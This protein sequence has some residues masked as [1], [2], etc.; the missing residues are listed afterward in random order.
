MLISPPYTL[1]KDDVRRCVPPIGLAYI[2]A[3]L[4]CNGYDVKILDAA[5]EGYTNLR[6]KDIFVTYGLTDEELKKKIIDFAP[7]IIGVSCIFSIQYHNVSHVLRIAKSIDSNI[8][9]IVGG[10]HP[11]YSLREALHNDDID[12]VV[13][14]EGEF[15]MLNLLNA[16]N[17]TD[18][19]KDESAISKISGVSFRKDGKY[20]INNNIEY[21]KDLDKLPFPARHLLNMEKYFEINLPQSPFPKG[22]RIA[23]L[24]TS[25]G[26]VVKCVFCTTTNFWGNRYRVRNAKNVI[27]E[28][29]ILK[30]EYKVD[31]IQITDDNFTLNKKRAKKIIENMGRFGLHWCMPQGIFIPSLDKDM[32]KRMCESGCYQLT[33][34]V[35]S[36][37]QDVLNNIIKKPLDLSTVKPL[38]NYAHELGIK[39]HAFFVSGFPGETKKQMHETYQFAKESCFDSASFFLATPLVG[40][41]LIRI[42][43]ENNY[44]RK[45]ASWLYRLYKT[46]NISTP[47]FTSTEAEELVRSFNKEFNKDDERKKRF[48]KNQ[49]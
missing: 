40:S 8:I 33:F 37:N 26:C 48:D 31:E 1:F 3:V 29:K 28:L 11:T 38:V 12:Y 39:V 49:Y 7:H 45:D 32:L 18:R 30:E 23:Q 20:H 14:H 19:K 21:I 43:K 15:A 13:M 9:T 10:S 44:L 2:A 41:E 36:G 46:G 27:E 25:R 42:C 35:E 34:A 24:V 4:E 6:Q 22:S 47:D 17:Q 16:L 5:A